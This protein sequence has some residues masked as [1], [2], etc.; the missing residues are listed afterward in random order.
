MTH[1][2]DPQIPDIVCCCFLEQETILTLLQL[3]QLYRPLF[4]GIMFFIRNFKTWNACGRVITIIHYIYSYVVFI[5]G[6]N[7]CIA[8]GR[9][10]FLSHAQLVA[11]KESTTSY[12]KISAIATYT[13]V[14]I[15]TS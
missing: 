14:A 8:T 12:I 2:S 6:N 7:S 3:T 13:G 11:T 4:V 5:E 9:S 10:L 1:W 15:A